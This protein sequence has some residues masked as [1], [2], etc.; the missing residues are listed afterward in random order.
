MVVGG[1]HRIAAS[2]RPG[3]K[4]IVVLCNQNSFSNAEIFA[5]AIKTL[6]RGK[7]VGE[8]TAG[9]VISTG[10]TAIMD[11]GVLRMPFRG[12]FLLGDG[13]DMELNGAVPHVTVRNLPQ[14]TAV[15]RDRQLEKA[16]QVLTRDVNAA[17]K[18]RRPGAVKASARKDEVDH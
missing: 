5:H 10:S 18:K 17:A 8:T 15:G 12:W 11:Y 2:T 3:Q 6:R 7:V 4:P 14:D 9:G 16:V 1:I 13:E